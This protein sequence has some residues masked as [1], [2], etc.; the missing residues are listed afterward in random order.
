MF[1]RSKK[2]TRHAEV[3]PDMEELPLPS[4]EERVPQDRAVL[5]HGDGHRRFHRR[6]VGAQDPV[7]DLQ[8]PRLLDAAMKGGD[9]N[10]L[11]AHPSQGGWAL[12]F[13]RLIC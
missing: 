4:G 9:P 2:E 7:P 13:E 8:R 10:L 3:A 5:D 12:Y 1:T 6:S 11:Q